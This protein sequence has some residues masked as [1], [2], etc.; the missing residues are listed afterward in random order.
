MKVTLDKFY[1]EIRPSKK[2][3]KITKWDF[4]SIVLI[5][6]IYGA[7]ALYNLGD[8]KIPSTQWEASKKEENLD[9]DFSDRENAIVEM[10]F[11][12]GRFGE[13]EGALYESDD[14]KHWTKVDIKTDKTEEY[15]TSIQKFAMEDIYAWGKV[16][17]KITKPYVR[18]MC[19]GE[20]IILHELAFRDKTGKL[21]LPQNKEDYSTL[22]DEQK[23]CKTVNGFESGTYFDEVYYARTAYEMINGLDCYETTHPPLGKI[24][25]SI[26][27]RIFGFCPFGWRIMGT[28]FG[29]AMLPIFYL[30][31]KQLFSKTSFAT[32]STILFAADF[33]HFTQTR[34]ATIDVYVTFF[35]I[36]MYYFM[37][38]YLQMSFYDTP[39]K[40]TLKPLLGAGISMGFAC[41]CKWTGV[42]AAIGLAILFFGILGVR[43][44]EYIYA[45]SE[46]EGSSNGIVHKHI[47]STFKRNVII[48]VLFCCVVFVLIP[49][50]IYLLSYIPFRDGEEM[51]LIERMIKNQKD[52]FQFHTNVRDH[53]RFSSW[54]F[55]WPVMTK[56]ILYSNTVVSQTKQSNISAFG[57]PLVW[58]AGIPAFIYMVY[59]AF[60]KRDG[61]SIFLCISYL[62]QLMPWAYVSRG[63][64]IYHY[65][66][67]V[68]FVVLMLGYI[69]YRICKNKKG[70]LFKFNFS[71][72]IAYVIA[73][74][75]L[76]VLFYPV[77]SGYPV[78][79]AFV[80]KYLRWLDTWFLARI[81]G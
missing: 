37:Y 58:W 2:R 31:A 28:L 30:L 26:G 61:I 69:M 77:I 16:T 59:R 8:F 57:N 67:S 79:V 33:M 53:H 25:I 65:F 4:V 23:L 20:P 7:I 38:Q 56:P 35:I 54:Y 60:R 3:K 29:I 49:A 74:I 13:N 81:G 46:P 75:G 40:K 50:A 78:E 14:R 44:L 41:A 27:I 17:C 64:F 42:Y 11:F 48:T 32:F 22:F 51:G 43:G 1:W 66:P 39:I 62:A 21:I 71:F 63:T 73:T 68:P 45:K 6:V 15:I 34:I 76:F 70:I 5:C 24:I 72:S 19:K 55:E 52:M 10:N 47:L 12:L 80:D 9:F 18:L 36:L